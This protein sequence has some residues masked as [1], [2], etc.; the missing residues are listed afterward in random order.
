LLSLR[1]PL[2]DVV[3]AS[4]DPAEAARG[5]IDDFHG[6]ALKLV[7]D[8]EHEVTSFIPSQPSTGCW[9]KPGAARREGGAATREPDAV[10]SLTRIGERLHRSALL[11]RQHTDA[12][13][14]T[15]VPI[16]TVEALT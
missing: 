2:S 4:A 5:Y 13:F 15:S 8:R 3:V 9:G 10:S 1:E 14:R 16:D 7:G 12:E 11:D 6:G